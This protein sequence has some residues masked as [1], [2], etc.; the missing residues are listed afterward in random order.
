MRQCL[1]SILNQTLKDIE[2][3]CIDDG[4]ADN[5]FS[6]LEEYTAKD[7]RFK[8]FSQK[9]AGS[10]VAKNTGINIANGEYIGFVDS[11]DWIS[12]DYFEVLYKTA[13]DKKADI[14]ATGNVVL[15]YEDGSEKSK[16]MGFYNMQIIK[17]F[18]EK[19]KLII[20]SGVVWNKIYKKDF[21]NNKNIRFSEIQC[22]G[23]DNAFNIAAIITSNFIAGTKIPKYFYR[24]RNNSQ[25]FEEKTEKHL[26]IIDIYKE[27]LTKKTELNLSNKW[28]DVIYKRMKLD[29][30]WHYRDFNLQLKKEFLNRVE[31][32][33]PGFGLR[34][35]FEMQN[36]QLIVSLTSYPARI[37]TVHQVIDTLL[38][39]TKK[40]DEVVLWLADSQFPNKEKD[41]PFELLDLTKKGLTISWCEDI[42]SYKKLIP[43]LKKYPDS[44]IVTADDDN[45]YEKD[46]LKKLHESYL[47]NPQVIH[48][49]RASLMTFRNCKLRP[50]REWKVCVPATRKPSFLNFLTGVGGVLYPPNV[51]YKDVADKELFMNLSPHGDDIWFWAMAVLNGK[52]IK[53]ADD[54]AFRQNLVDGTQESALWRKNNTG[55]RNDEQLRKVFKKYPAVLRKIRIE[56]TRLI[57]KELFSLRWI[58]CTDKEVNHKVFRI[59]GLKIKIRNDKRGKIKKNL[60][61]FFESLA[62][63]KNV[64]NYK[65]FSFLFL[66]IKTKNKHKI[67]LAQL[68]QNQKQISALNNKLSFLD[69]N[70]AGLKNQK[71]LSY[72]HKEDST[73]YQNLD[74][75]NIERFE[76]EGLAAVTADKIRGNEMSNLDRMFLNGILRKTRP[77]KIV[78]FGVAN[79]GSAAVILNAIK[80]INGAKLYS[81]DYN[82]RCYRN[83][84]KNT[85]WM[86]EERFS[87][88]AGKWELKTGGVCCKFLDSITNNG[89]DKIDVCLLDTVH[90]NPGEFLN[91]LEILPYMKKNGII[92]IHDTALQ[93][94]KEFPKGKE[95]YTC[96]VLLNTL[97]GKRIS[98]RSKHKMPI[99]PNIGAI[100]LCDDVE[101]LHWALFANLALP[102]N[103]YPFRGNDYDELRSHFSRHYA[104]ELVEIF[105]KSE[106]FYK[107]QLMKK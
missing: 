85:G 69:K 10:G 47:K 15:F 46:W 33:F 101:S 44:I 28:I 64:G 77:Q 50:Y 94:L 54:Y 97:Q 105:T 31:E 58:Y 27:I 76:S 43:A 56:R 48:C 100:V 104:P 3:I 78:E 57:G 52:K 23:E 40:A 72:T 96:G 9:N 82:T 102:W 74:Y 29:F 106:D 45:I 2:I 91:I 84:T 66:K 30:S 7:S 12:P 55:G 93:T 73:G 87:E 107:N 60:K 4:S 63:A 32:K 98:I 83:N 92:I 53:I 21:L 14:S 95:A 80:D 51:F 99:L 25:V 38:S 16:D 13:K 49:H 65:V 81:L 17:S 68:E 61:S 75:T 42:K 71:E 89:K 18:E 6:V 41:L 11:D 37:K 88:L 24:Q 90:F 34:K 67:L 103:F 26:Q 59:F 1:D 79:G 8:I 22:T 19:S 70:I 20:A 5:S 39:Q 62:G 36:R 35:E 86:I